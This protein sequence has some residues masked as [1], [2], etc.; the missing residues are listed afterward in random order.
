[1]AHES[2]VSADGSASSPPDEAVL[3]AVR[4]TCQRLFAA[5]DA[6]VTSFRTSLAQLVPELQHMMP[7]QGTAVADGLAR[8]VLWA[9]L[10]TEPP[11]VVE[12]TFRNVGMEYGR[13]GFP[14]GGYHGAGHALLRAARDAH[15]SDWSSELSSAWVAYYAWLAGHLARGAA[16]ATGPGPAAWPP[17]D[18]EPSTWA[19]RPGTEPSP[20]AGAG[21]VYS[22]RP[23]AAGA[24][25]TPRSL[26]DVLDLLRA[27][28]FVGNEHALG[29]IVTRVAVRTGTNLLAPSPELRTDPTAIANVIAVLQVM[30]YLLP[31]ADG[32]HPTPSTT[33]GSPDDRSQSRWFSRHR[34]D[35]M[36]GWGTT[37]PGTTR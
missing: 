19:A 1:M 27:A 10:T 7:D 33:H 22:A 26:D 2:A 18:P 34:S 31:A 17:T 8:A 32:R 6:F 21:A 24:F 30:G 16:R 12:E 11:Q 20:G 3:E 28:H 25:P 15:R 14:P 4:G 37:L 29:A 35:P 36:P 13:L 9:A 5:E 23:A